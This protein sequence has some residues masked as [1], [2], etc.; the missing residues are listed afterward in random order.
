MIR[1]LHTTL[2][3]RR[4]RPA[5]PV[6]TPSTRAGLAAHGLAAEAAGELP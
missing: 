3:A 2:A 5:F 4:N 6:R 1:V